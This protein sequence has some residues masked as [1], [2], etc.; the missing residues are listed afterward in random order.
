MLRRT[1]K[2]GLI[3]MNCCWNC[4]NRRLVTVTEA[5]RACNVN[6]NTVYLW[7]KQGVIE[8]VYNVGGKR[9]VYWDSLVNRG[10]V[11]NADSTPLAPEAA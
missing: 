6:I 10:L 4:R 1:E 9:R 5:A 3:E 11:S 8:W 2:T 7:M